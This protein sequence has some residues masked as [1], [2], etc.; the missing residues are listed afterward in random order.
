[1]GHA[2]SDDNEKAIFHAARAIRDPLQREVYLEAACAD[3]R[4]LRLRV[5]SLISALADA[6]EFLESPPIEAED[7][8]VDA[9]AFEAP[10]STIGPYRLLEVIGE[11]GFGSVYM[12]DQLEPIRRRV[13]L[14][15]IKAGM[16]TTQVIARFEA[17][18]QA[19]ALMD[20]P[21]I[22][23]ILDAGATENGRPYFVMELVR[24]IPVTE[25]CDDRNL[26]PEER[27]SLFMQICSAV[28]HAHQ[29]GIIH[30]DIK[31]SNILVATD[32]DRPVPKVI[33]FGIAKATQGRLTDKTLFTQFRQFIGTPAY[34]SPEQ[35]QIS[36]VDVDT[37]SDIYSLG[38]LLYE[39]LTGKT[40]LD[41]QDLVQ[42]GY[43]EICRRIRHEE[44][45]LPSKRISSLEGEELKTLAKNRQLEVSQFPTSVRGDLDWIVMKAVEKD[46]ARRYSTAESLAEDVQR[47]L[48]RQP[49]SAA[50]P[51]AMYRL[52]RLA[53]RNRGLFVTTG[54]VAAAL[55]IGTAIAIWQAVRATEAYSIA[56]AE[57]ERASHAESV[58]LDQRDRLAQAERQARAA[59]A[60]AEES[61]QTVRRHLYVSQMGNAKRHFDELNT[62]R[63]LELLQPWIPEADEADLR[64]FEW[65][66]L[67]NQCHQEVFT[68]RGHTDL[69]RDIG[70]S[71]DG[72]WL[73]TG[74][75]DGYVRLWDMQ[76]LEEVWS[77]QGGR[78]CNGVDISPDNKR[79]VA[80]F[81]QPVEPL[82]GTM[83]NV[84][85]PSAP[86][87]ITRFGGSGGKLRFAPDGTM[88]TGGRHLD[89]SGKILRELIPEQEYNTGQALSKD[90]KTLAWFDWSG[91]G[92]IIDIP[93]QEVVGE[94]PSH[95]GYNDLPT[96]GVAISPIDDDV[97][98][99]G[100]LSL[101]V[102]IW[103]RSGDLVRK[104]PGF[105]ERMPIA[106]IS[107][108]KDGDLLAVRQFLGAIHVFDTE[109]WQ[110][111]AILRPPSAGNTVAFT[112]GE[113]NLLVAGGEDGTIRGWRVRPNRPADVTLDQPA[114]VQLLR[115]SPDG[116][117]LAVGLDDGSVWFRSVETGEKVFATPSTWQR[118]PG[119]LGAAHSYTSDFIA[120]SPD[121]RFAAVIGPETAV[122]IWD[123]Q[124]EHD[125]AQ[126]TLPPES[127][128]QPR[129]VYW[130][131]EFS[132]EGD[133]LYAGVRVS[134][135]GGRLDV[136]QWQPEIPRLAK[137]SEHPVELS[138]V[139]R[140]LA[141]SPDGSVLASVPTFELTTF[142]FRTPELERLHVL[143]S[144]VSREGFINLA[145]SRDGSQLAVAGDGVH[146]WNVKTGESVLTLPNMGPSAHHV[147]WSED[148]RRLAV[149]DSLPMTRLWDL[150]TQQ[151]VATFP[152]AVSAF[153]PDGTILAVGHQ[154]SEFWAKDQAGRVTLYHAPPLAEIEGDLVGNR[155]VVF[156]QKP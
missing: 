98:V 1:M 71:R 24:G 115:F 79:L 74:A 14:K 80:H 150:S 129:A 49:V 148:G 13:A 2:S 144:D 60:T 27:L 133:R 62:S 15:I 35:A 76:T 119:T 59:Q 45:L 57:T 141:V 41:T 16:D 99:T 34:M 128:S 65:R 48:S 90:G 104:L 82:A 22:A 39:L 40:P 77:H 131:L 130:S 114:N 12:A 147:S 120:F 155:I 125:V 73:V 9:E 11:G 145:F 68:L 31:P 84:E 137:L 134:A 50:P 113:N 29:K 7:S 138:E 100:C 28:Q 37:R 152:G 85:D 121:N 106:M 111:I 81:W 51:S 122:G 142:L 149:S 72:R 140:S 112:P 109:T 126:V 117:T 23:K 87:L 75:T 56:Q 92:R 6:G 26:T 20:H 107:F 94:L 135:A 96:K 10:G 42:A 17:E 116:H 97:I 55:V 32:G 146:V 153:S 123:L 89:Q 70:F 101:G 154:G 4:P 127:E 91:A 86:K 88:W 102:C 43:D 69:L 30:R 61:E 110:R 8:S 18:R 156:L 53:S 33:D 5:D 78:H 63:T 36:A 93:S 83:W 103:N 64:G 108:S 19:L 143:R 136:L 38:V 124:R 52:R 66:W 46:R 47:H 139:N 118:S 58:A 54:A 21:Y 132:S 44:A 3:D 95:I 67:W 105:D 25:Y 151:V